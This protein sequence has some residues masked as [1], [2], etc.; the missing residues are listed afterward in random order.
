MG[1]DIHAYK[2][3]KLK[4]KWH[5]YGESDISRRYGVFGLMAGVRAYGDEDY[6]LFE[7][8]GLP[9]DVC[10]V[11]KAMSD[12]WDTDGHSHSYLTSDELVTLKNKLADWDEKKEEFYRT[13]YRKEFGDVES[14]N[15]LDYHKERN[16]ELC[17]GDTEPRHPFQDVR[18]V[19]WFDN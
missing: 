5:L 4:G 11:T 7:P 10:P 6:K 17:E 12:H 18:L 1:C 3:V 19:F 16:G 8:K 9:S 13:W 2:E 15:I 14:L